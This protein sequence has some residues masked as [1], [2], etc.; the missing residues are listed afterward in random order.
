[1]QIYVKLAQFN[2][3]DSAKMRSLRRCEIFKF[4]HLCVGTH[5]AK[6]WKNL[7]AG[8]PC[9]TPLIFDLN[10]IFIFIDSGNC[11]LRANTLVQCSHARKDYLEWYD[12]PDSH[13]CTQNKW[14]PVCTARGKFQPVQAKGGWTVQ[15]TKKFC[16]SSDGSRLN[17]Q[18]ALEDKTMNCLCSRKHHE[19]Q[20]P[21][22]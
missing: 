15:A 20:Q 6:I 18:A 3:S 14:E 7:Q 12:N 4:V 10:H 19:L 21:P 13:N 22:M 2:I 5:T 1:M 8:N 17:G 11:T 9:V 16:W